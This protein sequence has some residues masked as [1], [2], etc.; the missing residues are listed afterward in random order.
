MSVIQGEKLPEPVRNLRGGQP[1]K[2]SSLLFVFILAFILAKILRGSLGAGISG[3]IVTFASVLLGLL[4]FDWLIG[5]IIGLFA[6][7]FSGSFLGGMFLAGAGGYRSGGLPGWRWFYGWWGWFW[8]RGCLRR[9]VMLE[10]FKATS[11]TFFLRPVVSK[12]IFL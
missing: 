8:W 3:L 9:L 5:L 2:R 7:M 6:S 1:K 11:K 10:K 12:K 4:F